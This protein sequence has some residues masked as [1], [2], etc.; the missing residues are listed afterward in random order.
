MVW[1]QERRQRGE[2][3]VILCQKAGSWAAHP[4]YYLLLFS[5]LLGLGWLLVC[6]VDNSIRFRV[7]LCSTFA[8]KCEPHEPF[9]E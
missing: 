1:S 2:G 9:M 5:G 6:G 4:G 8:N 7:F 3:L